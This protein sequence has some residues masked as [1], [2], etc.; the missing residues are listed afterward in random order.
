M[1]LG[2]IGLALSG[3]SATFDALTRQGGET[4]ARGEDRLAVV[5]VPDERVERLSRMFAPQ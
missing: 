3:R 1:K 2:I 4:A 5:R